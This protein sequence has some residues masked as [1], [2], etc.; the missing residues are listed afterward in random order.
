MTRIPDNERDVIEQ[1]IYLPMVLSVL[2]RDLRMIEKSPFKLKKPYQ[3]LIQKTM[4]II[5]KELAAVKHHLQKNNIRVKKIKSDNAFTMYMFFYKGYEEHHNYFNPRLRNR[6]EEL[7]TD[8]LGS[9]SRTKSQARSPETEPTP[10][11]KE[12]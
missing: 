10:K 4:N 7:L 6:V 3:E 2:R 8:Y 9:G 11:K 12:T 5:Q 1:A